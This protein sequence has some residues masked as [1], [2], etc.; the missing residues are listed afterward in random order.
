M[1]KLVLQTCSYDTTNLEEKQATSP[2][3]GYQA[4]GISR[5]N[6]ERIPCANCGSTGKLE[7][8]LGGQI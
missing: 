6:L 5:C 4:E 7:A 8:K 3:G 2:R 1:K